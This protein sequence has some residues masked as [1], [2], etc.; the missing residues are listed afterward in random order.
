MSIIILSDEENIFDL[1]D[2]PS[3]KTLKTH[4]FEKQAIFMPIR[5]K[6]KEEEHLIQPFKQ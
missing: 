2:I 1:Q 3:L 6:V 4:S 5:K